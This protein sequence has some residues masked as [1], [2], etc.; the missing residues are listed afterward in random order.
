VL[1]SPWEET[2]VFTAHNNAFISTLI[3][4]LCRLEAYYCR[5]L[6]T[7]QRLCDVVVAAADKTKCEV[8]DESFKEGQEPDW[9]KEDDVIQR[10]V[11]IAII[12]IEDPVRPEV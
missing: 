11:C 7:D 5:L 6:S 2:A 10:L 3:I 12:G 4:D 9:N 1:L 8:Y